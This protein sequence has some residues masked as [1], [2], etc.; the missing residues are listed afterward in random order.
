MNKL[1]YW[2]F[3]CLI[4]APCSITLSQGTGFSFQGR[5]QDNG[6]VANGNYDLIFAAFDAEGGGIQQ[7][8]PVTANNVPVAN[9]QFRVV[10]DF[11]ANVFTGGPRWLQISVRKSG[12]AAPPTALS[13]RHPLLPTPY[14]IYAANAGTVADGM[15]TEAKLG[16]NAVGAGGLQN[17]AVTA[18]KIA[19]GSV[20]KSLNGL[21]DDVT[22][23]AVGNVTLTADGNNLTIASVGGGGSGGD[24]WALNNTSAYYA[25]GHV[26]IG[27]PT[28]NHRLRISGGPAWT[29]HAW[30]GALELDNAAAI[31]WNANASGNHFGVGQ[32]TDGFFIFSTASN[33]GAGGIPPSYRMVIDNAG[34]MGVGTP[35]GY[36]LTSKLT[37][38]EPSAG[39][40]WIIPTGRRGSALIS[41][42]TAVGSARSAT[43]SCISSSTA[44]ENVPSSKE[45]RWPAR[46]HQSSFRKESPALTIDINGNVGIGTDA[47]GQ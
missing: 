41:T 33:P 17:K 5:L 22:L 23:S 3:A 20:V 14:A 35:W 36:S 30:G 44:A 11:G 28:P 19:E 25:A 34:N 18:A 39:Y 1:P 16:P 15:I 12:G 13:P 2:L 24:I 27:T 7:G 46:C 43:T 6:A 26:G 31:A 47:G 9:G 37:V 29:G 40:S 10:L 38:Y 45:S 8:S 21:R 42:V 4:L 32:T